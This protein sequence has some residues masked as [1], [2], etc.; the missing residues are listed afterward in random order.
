MKTTIRQGSIEDW[1]T[2]QKLNVCVFADNLQ[3]DKHQDLNWSGSDDGAH[4]Y[5][6]QLGDP[7]TICLI[8]EQ[9]G[10]SIGYIVASPKE[11][12][13]RIRKTYEIQHMGVAPDHRSQGIGSMLILELKKKCKEAGC[14]SL[15]VSVYFKNKSGIQFYEKSGFIPIDMGMEVSI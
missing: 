13:Y 2:I 9:E 10:E 12:E 11:V 14:D 4:F 8:A 3:Y 6:K 7:D 1:R 5:K 15:Y